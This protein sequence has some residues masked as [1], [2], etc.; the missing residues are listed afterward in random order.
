[1]M[2]IFIIE[3]VLVLCTAGALVYTLARW[4][5]AERR[6]KAWQEQN[7]N[8]PIGYSNR[9]RCNREWSRVRLQ[10]VNF[11]SSVLLL[12]WRVQNLDRPTVVIAALIVHF[13]LMYVS[14]WALNE[15]YQDVQSEGEIREMDAAEERRKAELVVMQ[16]G[17]E[18]SD[19]AAIDRAAGF[20]EKLDTIVERLDTMTPTEGAALA[21]TESQDAIKAGV[22][23]ANNKLDHLT[24]QQDRAL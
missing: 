14:L 21:T 2:L 16:Q 11:V 17:Q 8:G 22:E 15:T 23:D 3:I 19:Q 24:E 10:R 7:W 13:P 12:L 6:R 1:M 9:L 20:H 4:R 5:V 18:R